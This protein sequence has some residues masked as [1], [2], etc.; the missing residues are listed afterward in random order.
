[1]Y[2]STTDEPW[3][4]IVVLSGQLAKPCQSLVWLYHKMPFDA[5][6]NKA[7]KRANIQILKQNNKSIDK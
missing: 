5:F 4:R 3:T 6:K 1:M 2:L 7:E